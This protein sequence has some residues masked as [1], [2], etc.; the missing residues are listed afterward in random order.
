VPGPRPAG[1]EE[2][3]ALRLFIAVGLPEPTLRACSELLA[4]VGGAPTTTGASSAVRWVRHEGLHLTLRFLG[5]TPTHRVPELTRVTTEVAAAAGP[6]DVTLHGGGTFPDPRRPRVLWVGVTSGH[7]QLARLA[8]RLSS[9]LAE[10]GWPPEDR[11]FR[12]HLTVARADGSPAAAH[13]A[14]QLIDAA[15]D[16]RAAFRADHLTLYRS[17]LGHGPARYEP[18]VEAPLGAAPGNADLPHGRS[19]R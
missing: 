17:V 16:W 15:A 14:G 5:A 19:E 1:R 12:A 18:L 8:G 7:D 6:F 13:A 9:P 11:P 4:R 3:A 2:P 10:L